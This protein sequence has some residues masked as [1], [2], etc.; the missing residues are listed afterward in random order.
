MK[1]FI[2]FCIL[3]ILAG[4][5]S[6]ESQLIS[7]DSDGNVSAKKFDG[8]PILV[9]VPEKIGF[10]VTESTYKVVRQGFDANGNPVDS[11]ESTERSV[12]VDKNPI[13]LGRTQLFTTDVK[14]PM[15]GTAKNSIELDK[16]VKY[17]TKVSTD[18]DDKTLG[19]IIDN[20]DN[21]KN[22]FTPQSG[23]QADDGPVISRIL[24]SEKQY[25][26]IY[27]PQFG[28]FDRFEL[29]ENSVFYK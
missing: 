24:I 26:M 20:L 12:T 11:T 25:M 4:C 9:T 5:S 1:Q 22:V 16:D 2:L 18:V 28:T 14:R 29:N 13:K 7:I 6:I 10:L 15:F 3:T 27:D 21:I 23:Q 19:K 8:V 17:P